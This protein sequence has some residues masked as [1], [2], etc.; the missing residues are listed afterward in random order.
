MGM[1]SSQARLLSLTARQHNIELKSQRLQAE[2]LRMANDSDNAYKNY[3]NALESTKTNALI[4]LQDGTIGDTLLTADKIFTYHTLS[5]QYSLKNN[6]GKTLV[7]STMHNAYKSTNSLHEFLQ[8]FGLIADAEYTVPDVERNPAY[9][10]A[11]KDWEN[12]HDK[13]E[14]DMKQYEKDYDKWLDDHEYWEDVDHPGWEA[15]EPDPTDPKYNPTTENL[16][17]KFMQAGS[18]C[19]NSALRGGIGCYAH[20]LAHIIDYGDTTGFGNDGYNESWYNGTHNRYTTS[21]GES[22]VI[23]GSDITGAGMDDDGG[24]KCQTMK[25]VSDK[26]NDE[27]KFLAAKKDGETCNIDASST[28]GEKLISKWKPDGSLKSI[29]QWAKDLYYLCMYDSTARKY[30]YEKL[31][32]T[33]QE[34][35][36]SV[37]DFQE[38]LAGSVSFDEELYNQDHNIWIND[39]PQEPMPPVKPEEPI[40]EDFT[41]GIPEE[42]VKPDKTIQTTTFTNENE[43]KWYINQWYKMEGLDKTPE[44]KDERV[45]NTTTNTYMHIYSIENVTKSNTTYST[46]QD[47]G[48]EENENYLVMKD[49][50]LQNDLWLHNMIN[51]GYI[52]IQVFD[53]FEHKFINTSVGVDS[54]LEEV[55]DEQEIKKAEAEYE[56]K[57]REINKKESRVDEEL[58]KLEAERSA[59]DTQQEDLKKIIRDNVDLSFKLFS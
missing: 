35:I 2:K 3:L 20:I 1:S 21:T 44:I 18:S 31:G 42:I 47:W 29:K 51:E 59:I 23:S 27:T 58:S 55:P 26:I 9:D 22:F 39:E 24:S 33:K 40:L 25:E 14:E 48:T 6:E 30:N 49:E 5:K 8:H 10:Q 13:W 16:G 57:M 34:M 52:Q 17:D 38:G 45:F 54:R 28:E 15:S 53:D 19:Y 43:A 46:N 50:M 36:D 41:N 37:T 32:L 7:S 11:I 56:A 12:A 4:T